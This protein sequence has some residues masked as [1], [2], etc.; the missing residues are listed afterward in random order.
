MV[1]FRVLMILF[2]SSAVLFGR[3]PKIVAKRAPDGFSFAPTMQ[4][5]GVWG[6]AKPVMLHGGN[7]DKAQRGLAR[8]LWDDRAV[9]FL[10][11]LTDREI[12]SPGKR[13][14]LENY[15]LGD[16]VEAFIGRQGQPAYVEVHATP[17]GKKTFYFYCGSRKAVPPPTGAKG[18]RV[19]S[20]RT[21][22]GWRAMIVIPWDVLG[23][24]SGEGDWGVFFGRYDYKVP[25]GE[26]SLSC[27][28]AQR[29]G[30]PDFHR[31]SS[32]ATMQ[33]KP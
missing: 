15:R 17:A 7:G 10:F 26:R 24:R 4:D 6:R 29:K 14:G 12:V 19:V 8:A 28:P 22:Q 32:Y 20:A 21:P 31:R 16:T 5:E 30:K 25:D 13:D 2:A 3:S 27:Y 33:L 23:G 18:I 9:Y 11:D 1:M